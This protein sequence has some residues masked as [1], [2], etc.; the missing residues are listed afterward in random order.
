[1]EFWS[2][3]PNFASD[4]AD[5]ASGYESRGVERVLLIPL[6]E[7]IISGGVVGGAGNVSISPTETSPKD[8][9][10]PTAL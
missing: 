6:Y 2:G 8:L 7:S 3:N 10:H 5:S 1:M 9:L 4:P